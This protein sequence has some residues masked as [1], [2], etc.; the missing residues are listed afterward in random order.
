MSDTR[1]D[2]TKNEQRR[3]SED[4][5]PT[6]DDVVNEA[7]SKVDVK[8][9]LAELLADAAPDV[10]SRIDWALVVLEEWRPGTFSVGLLRDIRQAELARREES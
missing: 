7:I 9:S 5:G 1:N 10:D 8:K 3:K 4:F 2:E 6:V